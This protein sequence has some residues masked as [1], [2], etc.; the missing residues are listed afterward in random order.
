LARLIDLTLAS[1]IVCVLTGASV[2]AAD[3]LPPPPTLESGEEV[4]ELG[5]GWYLRGD[6][7][8]VDYVKPE[9]VGFGLPGVTLLDR[10]R[11]DKTFSVGGGIGYQFTSWFR[12][13]LTV[14]YRPA[15][16]FSGTR[17]FP[18]YDIGFVRDKADFES[19]TGLVNGYVDLGYWAGVTPY[20]GAGIGVS[21]NRFT[22]IRRD[23]FV[24][25]V[26]AGSAVLSPHTTYN[27]AWALMAGVAVNVGS[28][29]QLDL[30][31]RFSH[32]GDVRTR[33]DAPGPGIRT[34]A[35]RAHEFRLG[36]RYMID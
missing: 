15:A 1:A 17:P 21:G 35:I 11:L 34:D 19:T 14:D 36:A 20:F 9:D 16:E 29:F 24:G 18:T 23:V 13:D 4:V 32:L 25:G 22:N 6:I 26:P 3:L 10:E 30:G 8:Y 2:R 5:T 7:G 31:Y 27:L 28:G 33:L 12:A